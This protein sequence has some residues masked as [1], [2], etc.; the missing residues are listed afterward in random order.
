MLAEPPE[1]VSPHAVPVEPGSAPAEPSKLITN[2]IGMKLVL[3]PAG[4]FLMGSPDSD[5]DAEVDEK[6]QHRVWITRLFYLGA[7]AVT[8]SQY[9]AA[10]SM[11]PSYFKESNDL[12]VEQISWE[13]AMAFCARLNELEKGKLLGANSYRLPTEAEWE[14]ACRAGSQWRFGFG[15]AYASLGNYAWFEDN[16]VGK[17]HPVGR[18]RANAWGLHDMHGNVWEWCW[19]A[20]DGQYYASSPAD[21]P[22]GPDFTGAQDR[23]VRG[24]SWSLNPGSCRAAKRYPGAPG[25]RD[26]NLGF[27][28]ARV[29]SGP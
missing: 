25:D 21:D 22:R 20:Y 23:V 17:T 8:Q 28:V 27:R 26:F 9:R 7:T 18:K 3:I 1:P 12:P 29:W 4:E 10:T 13:D 15:D 11:T 2:S 5:K 14:Y 19:D 6:P 24:G 16:S